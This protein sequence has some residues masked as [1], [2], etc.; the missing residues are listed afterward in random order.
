MVKEA[1]EKRSV[2][3]ACAGMNHEAGRLIHDNDRG[4]F[5]DHLELN[6][7][8]RLESERF[9]ELWRLEQ[10]NFVAFG[11]LGADFRRYRAVELHGAVFDKLCQSRA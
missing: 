10:L 2:G 11:S 9:V 5:I 6:E 3:V 4:V 7:R 1:I 8:L